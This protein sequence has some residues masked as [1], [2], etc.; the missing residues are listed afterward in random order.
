MV[1]ILFA[2]LY[3]SAFAPIPPTPKLQNGFYEVLD[4]DSKVNAILF[5]RSDADGSL[6]IGNRL[7]DS[8]GKVEIY[9]SLSNDNNSFYF[10]LPQ[11]IPAGIADEMG[12][13]TDN[14]IPEIALVIEGIC[15]KAEVLRSYSNANG[16]FEYRGIRCR[17]EGIANARK[18]AA[19]FKVEPKLRKHPGHQLLVKWIPDQESYSVGETVKLKLQVTNVGTKPVCLEIK[20]WSSR[21]TENHPEAFVFRFLAQIERKWGGAVPGI[22]SN[23]RISPG[24][25]SYYEI[26]SGESFTTTA[27]LEKWYNFTEAETY[28]ITG[29]CEAAVCDFEDKK[30]DKDRLW[31]ELLVAD[32]LVK[33]KK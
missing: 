25:P 2:S 7:G 19:F 8:F 26:K 16:P 32:C 10:S 9:S 14:K 28:R 17:I 21:K 5:P 30:E 29:T 11:A 24:R 3:L 20:D 18:I 31:N 22:E 33:V 12:N 27:S 6:S 23:H 4:K 1:P 15:V 13:L